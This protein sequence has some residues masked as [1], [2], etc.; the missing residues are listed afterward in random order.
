MEPS[1]RFGFHF[2]TTEALVGLR[3]SENYVRFTFKKGGAAHLPR[4]R[5]RAQ[6]VGEILEYFDFSVEIKED[7]AFAMAAEGCDQETMKEKLRVL[8]YLMIHTRQLDMVMSNYVLITKYRQKIFD[9]INL[10]V[11]TRDLSS[12]KPSCKEFSDPEYCN[13]NLF[14]EPSPFTGRF[15]HNVKN[16]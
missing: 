10:K 6:F 12:N 9:D 4:R 15:H 16:I 14:S 3:S 2:S 8:G 7:N 11:W 5:R 1:S 13:F